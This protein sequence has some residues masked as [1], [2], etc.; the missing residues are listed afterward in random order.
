M[1]RPGQIM[2]FTEYGYYASLRTLNWSRIA[3]SVS[4]VS[5]MVNWWLDTST[6]RYLHSNAYCFLLLLF[7]VL[8]TIFKY[9]S[10]VTVLVAVL[11][12]FW[13][14]YWHLRLCCVQ[15]SVIFDVV[16]ANRLYL[17]PLSPGC[18]GCVSMISCC[19][20]GDED[21]YEKQ[22]EVQSNILCSNIDTQRNFIVYYVR[23][24]HSHIY[25]ST[26]VNACLRI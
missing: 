20:I 12:A 19:G 3:L 16:P 22:W 13:C 26:R 4:G 14:T 11:A 15:M 25:M 23:V 18:A 17:N 6:R 9:T 2:Y 5:Y 24:P 7:I 21:D 1:L 10:R 8:W